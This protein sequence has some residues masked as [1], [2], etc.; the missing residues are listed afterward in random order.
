MRKLVSSFLILILLATPGFG[1]PALTTANVNFREGPGTSFGSLGTLPSGT[2]V[3]LLDCN[4]SG[5]WCGIAHDG[6]EGF[7]SGK[8]LTE[9]EPKDVP[10]WPRAFKLGSDEA[11][12]VLYEPQF[13][14][15]TEFARIEAVIAA[16][17]RK[18]E[19]A[20]PIF[21][22]LGV[23]AQTTSDKAAGT[24]TLSNIEVTSLDF[25]ALGRQDLTR[26]A[27]EIG[28]LLPSDPI[29]LREERV[30]ASLAA[31]QQ[32]ADVEGLKADPPKVFVSETPARL[33]QTDG[34][35][36]FA[37]VKG[38]AGVEFVINTNWDLFRTDDTLYLRSEDAWLTAAALDGD[39]SAVDTLP[40][41]LAA[42]PDDGNW[43]NA[44]KAI[45][46]KPFKGAVPRILT[47]D[48][49]AELILFNGPAKL[50]TVPGTGLEWV[51]N[52]EADLFK[53]TSTGSWYYLVSGR[54]FSAPTLDGPWVFATPDLPDDFRNIPDDKPYYTVRASVPGTSE[55]NE[56]RLRASIPETARVEAGKIKPEIAYDGAPDFQA[57]EGTTL[58]YA[59][60]TDAQVIRVGDTYYAVQDGVWFMS[61]SP[62]GPWE[63]ARAVPDEIYTIPA[64]S[65]VHNVTYVRVYESEPDAVW[66]GYTSGYLWGYLAWGAIVY[67]T[68]WSY[69]PYWRYGALPI[70]YPRPV[71]FGIGAYYNP[72]YGTYG[73]YGYAY[74]PY[75]GI[76][77]RTVWNPA[78]GAYVRGARAYGPAGTRGFVTAYNP[79]TG[80]R[81]A[82]R[83]GTGVYGSWGSASV[84]RGSDYLRVKGAAGAA[85]GKGVRW[86]SS[87]GQGFAA[88]RR[89]N[90]YAGRDGN[91]YRNTGGGWQKWDGG[92]SPVSA[93]A[94]DTLGNSLKGRTPATRPAAGTNRPIGDRANRPATR[95][96]KVNRPAG[97]QRPAVT[98]RPAGTQRPGAAQRPATRPNTRPTT[99]PTTRQVPA[100]VRRDHGNRQT[101]NQRTMQRRAYSQPNRG[102]GRP[103]GNRQVQRGGGGRPGGG[104]GRRRR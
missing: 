26:L 49:P 70:Y 9:A 29:V 102:A 56:A 60:N 57:I 94:R 91:V 7:V 35:A 86:N 96:R 48:V 78:T 34:E 68:G 74:G 39:W 61:P 25:A 85:G 53:L 93:P 51:E 15:W 77:A 50:Q 3:E 27:V 31:Y 55:A 90:V 81:A 14:S 5:T 89:G 37:P 21:G 38:A 22:V 4:E 65:P 67:G 80:T 75:R 54:W 104:G 6:R 88:S 83:G 82:A 98:Q 18:T 2:Q 64:S 11:F 10:G 16:E 66:Y 28:G 36:V 8:Y 46:A 19:V 92:W 1:A 23:A 87:N 97:T 32:L 42:L 13:S 84:A 101:G 52:T 71:T 12:V 99:R 41:A 45:P 72:A 40:D 59:A 103:A 24:V 30:T 43:E 62:D 33:L 73:R 44:R 69:R 63:L 95:D 76:S 17:Y 58:S 47:S 79:V 100:Q 20:P